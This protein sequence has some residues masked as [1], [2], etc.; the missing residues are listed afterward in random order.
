[1]KTYRLVS[2]AIGCVA[3][4]FASCSDLDL[5]ESQYHSKEYQFSDFSQV[6]EADM[7]VE[8][9]SRHFL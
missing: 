8:R 9:C 4:A 2:L 1:M 7:T 6:K 5:N 3:F